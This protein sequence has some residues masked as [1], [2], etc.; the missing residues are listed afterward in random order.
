MRYIFNYSEKYKLIW[1][2]VS[3]YV[4]SVLG[5]LS[6]KIWRDMLRI[7]TKKVASGKNSIRKIIK[8]VY[9]YKN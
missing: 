2:R 5:E 1:K 9:Y 6:F 3:K 4:G 8:L 7:V